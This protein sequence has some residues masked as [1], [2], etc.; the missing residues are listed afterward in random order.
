MLQKDKDHSTT[1]KSTDDIDLNKQEENILKILVTQ[2]DTSSDKV[3][4]DLALIICTIFHIC[5]FIGCGAIL[6]F[7]VIEESTSLIQESPHVDYLLGAYTYDAA[8]VLATDLAVGE[9]YNYS[10]S[11]TIPVLITRF[12]ARLERSQLYYAR[13]L[14]GEPSSNIQPFKAFA[15]GLEEAISKLA[16]DEIR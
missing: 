15:S 11:F 8:T 6:I 16:C 1:C 13:L 3:T 14:Y 5:L 7:M 10:T 4:S 2:G 9:F 12:K